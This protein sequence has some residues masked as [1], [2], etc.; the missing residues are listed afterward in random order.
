MEGSLNDLVL[1][2]TIVTIAQLNVNLSIL[3]QE[4]KFGYIY[5]MGKKSFNMD[6]GFETIHIFFASDKFI[7]FF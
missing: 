1:F 4:S 6:Y 3:K 5:G 2:H 7:Y